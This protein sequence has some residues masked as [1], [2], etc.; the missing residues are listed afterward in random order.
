MIRRLKI[1]ISHK[2]RELR[3]CGS[4]SRDRVRNELA[5]LRVALMIAHQNRLDRAA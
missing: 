3:N 1:L 5:S 4:K 2:E